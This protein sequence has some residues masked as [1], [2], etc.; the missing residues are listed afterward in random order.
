MLVQSDNGTE[1]TN[2]YV[3]LNNPRRE[4][5]AVMGAFEIELGRLEVEHHLIKPGTPE[6]N[7]KIERFNGTIKTELRRHLKAG[8]TLVQ[9]IAVVTWYE[10]YYNNNR[11]HTALNGLTPHEK[12][13]GIRAARLA[14]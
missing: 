1:F 12:F 3:S 13:Y 6:L 10:N 14:G 8:M 11:P 9:I 4:K 5:E 2:K 7:G